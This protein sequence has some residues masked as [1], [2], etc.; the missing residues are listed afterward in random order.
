MKKNNK[1]KGI[2]LI[3][4]VITIIVLLILA[5]ISIKKLTGDNGIIDKTKYASF[6][7]KIRQYQEKVD[8]Y[9][10]DEAQKNGHNTEEVTVTDPGQIKNILGDIEEGDENKY[11]IQDDEL[12]YNPDTVTDQEKDWLAELG[13]L[14][15]TTAF[16][17]TFMVNGS[18]Y[19]TIQSDK[20]KF[21]DVN[22]TSTEGNFAGWYYDQSTT[23]QAI[24]GGEIT[25]DVTLY[26]KWG[27]F[28][29]TF[30]VDGEVY[31]TIEGNTLTFPSTNPTKAD[32]EFM[33]WFYDESKQ[34]RV[35][36]GEILTQNT[37]IYAGWSKIQYVDGSTYYSGTGLP[38]G[39]NENGPDNSTVNTDE[40]FWYV[41]LDNYYARKIIM[42]YKEGAEKYELLSCTG[43][44]EE[45]NPYLDEKGNLVLQ[46]NL[47]LQGGTS[48]TSSF[49]VKVTYANMEVKVYEVDFKN[50]FIYCLAEGT[51]IT[52][53]DM[54]RKNIE[55]I[56]YDNELLVWDFDNGCFAKAKP[57]WIKKTQV[58]EEYNLVKFDDGT[59]LKTVID[60]RIFN[61]E[62]QKFTYTM[63]EENTPIGTSV[64]KNDGSVARIVERNV[65]KEKV[66]YYNIITDY[67]M[68]LFANGLL[69]SLRLNNL[70]KIENMKFVK[71]DRKLAPR[72]EFESIPDKYFYGLR[73]AEQPKEINRGNDVKHTKT[74]QEY[75]KRLLPLER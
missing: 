11:V 63:D 8:N 70:Y 48:F 25:S 59:E 26:A 16:L 74:L 37:T 22:P 56:T 34:N 46:N 35:Q 30:M 13:I 61:M 40:G 1:E 7:T 65:V 3:A 52:L 60:H 66:N 75:V 33:G 17:L 53:A 68:N 64:F 19:Q 31:Q 42:K 49:S 54:S 5:G 58:A 14:A 57:L 4:L 50:V 32:Y 20:M 29:A 24:E 27:D 39:Y 18:V 9:V 45:Y 36:E 23:N 2:T 41:C 62:K 55:D 12:R 10:I 71:D 21:P 15:M 43:K 69:T 51:D 72:E 44:F 73:L 67:H 47:D 6:A 38:Y 28:V